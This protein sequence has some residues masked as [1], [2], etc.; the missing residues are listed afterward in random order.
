MTAEL[1]GNYT[2]EANFLTPTE[3]LGKVFRGSTSSEGA[4]IPEKGEPV[5]TREEYH[6]GDWVRGAKIG[7]TIEPIRVRVRR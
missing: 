2:N 4:T 3:V 7:E 6:I 1:S 5:G